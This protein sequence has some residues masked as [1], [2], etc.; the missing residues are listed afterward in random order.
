MDPVFIS[1]QTVNA[2]LAA[3][4]NEVSTLSMQDWNAMMNGVAINPQLSQSSVL[5]NHA[6]DEI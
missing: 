3:K 1:Q 6:V 2:S 5:I 4:A